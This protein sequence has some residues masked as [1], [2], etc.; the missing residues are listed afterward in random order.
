MVQ[1][2]GHQLQNLKTGS[3]AGFYYGSQFSLTLIYI[4]IY[5]YGS[6]ILIKPNLGLIRKKFTYVYP[7]SFMVQIT[8]DTINNGNINLLFL[9]TECLKTQG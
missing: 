1:N 7:K 9:L 2:Q 6:P 5:I 8:R 3:M 4:Y